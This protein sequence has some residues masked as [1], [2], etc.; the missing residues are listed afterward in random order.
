[1]KQYY[2][3]RDYIQKCAHHSGI[4]NILIGEPKSKIL[5]PFFFKKKKEHKPLPHHV[6]TIFLLVL[7]W[8]GYIFNFLKN[9]F[10]SILRAGQGVC[11]V[12]LWHQ[13]PE[14]KIFPS[15]KLGKS[16]F[17]HHVRTS[18]KIDLTWWESGLCSFIFQKRIQNFW[19]RLPYQS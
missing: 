2:S 16:P 13:K 18:R 10:F 12:P 11:D 3:N 4:I 19:F 14:E 9:T 7:M 15:P 6:R 5:K 17:L 8:W 1:M